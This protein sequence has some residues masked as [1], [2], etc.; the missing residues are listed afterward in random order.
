MS[1]RDVLKAVWSHL[2][3]YPGFWL[4]V[5]AAIYVAL[6][7]FQLITLLSIGSIQESLF[8]GFPNDFPAFDLQ[9]FLGYYFAYIFGYMLIGLMTFTLS[10]EAT[11]FVERG[12]G[13]PKLIDL[14][15]QGIS[16]YPRILGITLILTGPLIVLY[17]LGFASMFRNMQ[18]LFGAQSGT[19]I[20][21]GFNPV[22]PFMPC[23]ITIIMIPVAAWAL[24][25][26]QAAV[27]ENKGVV[28][29]LKTGIAFLRNNL[30]SI[31]RLALWL[32]LVLITI[33]I[34]QSLA[35]APFSIAVMIPA[36]REMMECMNATDT[37]EALMQCLQ[38]VQ[39]GSTTG[40]LQTITALLSSVGTALQSL[41]MVMSTTILFFRRN[42]APT[43]ITI[44][45]EI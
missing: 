7:I 34:V 11:G 41:V 3:E 23:G 28:Q 45:D 18:T 26:C 10:V 39:Q 31:V 12:E 24:F 44:A 30:S 32:I 4:E 35:M 19:D 13:T 42:V 36:Q 43:E 15:K 33:A 17:I 9:S 21:T 29:A 1:G 40:V 20:Q 37:P 22:V 2:K 8:S 38:Q 14:A 6:S 27:L 5:Y 25:S 16:K